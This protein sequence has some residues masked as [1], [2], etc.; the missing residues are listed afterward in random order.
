MPANH[1]DT[2]PLYDTAQQRDNLDFTTAKAADGPLVAAWL[3]ANCCVQSLPPPL[4]R[5]VQRWA[6]GRQATIRGLD[7]VLVH[8]GRG[9]WELPAEC[10]RPYDNGR[11]TRAAA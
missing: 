1:Y 4:R 3:Q 6:A 11:A 5:S 8:L 2:E 9:L 10:W 7:T